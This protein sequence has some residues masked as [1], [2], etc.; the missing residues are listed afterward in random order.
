[1]KPCTYRIYYE[2]KSMYCGY[3]ENAPAQGVIVISQSEDNAK[4]WRLITGDF[5]IFQSWG[6][7]GVDEF[8]LYD[9]L[10][11]SGWKKV[12]FGRTIPTKL[13]DEIYSKAREEAMND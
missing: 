7:E 9:Y 5:Y 12:L 2:D 6:W 13:F 11:S 10:M 8:G 1:M 4:G 3:P